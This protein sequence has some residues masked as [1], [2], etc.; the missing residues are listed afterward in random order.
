MYSGKVANNMPH[1]L[2]ESSI[3]SFSRGLSCCERWGG[4]GF[5]RE[6]LTSELRAEGP[7]YSAESAS[8]WPLPFYQKRTGLI[9]KQKHVYVQVW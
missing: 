7:F 5:F 1:S 6:L 8:G 2:D 3:H 4:G 9:F